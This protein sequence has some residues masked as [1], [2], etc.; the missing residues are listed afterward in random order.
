[1]TYL[2]EHMKIQRKLSPVFGTHKLPF[3]DNDQNLDQMSED[4]TT[5]TTTNDTESGTKRKADDNAADVIEDQES[6][7]VRVKIDDQADTAEQATGTSTEDTAKAVKVEE[8]GTTETEPSPEAKKEDDLDRTE[9]AA[10]EVGGALDV[11]AEDKEKESSLENTDSAT[12]EASIKD[13]GITESIPITSEDKDDNTIEA[14]TED[15]KNTNGSEEETEVSTAVKE[16]EGS[17]EI[18]EEHDNV[19]RHYGK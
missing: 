15:D 17:D 14:K 2:S 1:M 6:R 7:R 4:N 5:T 13:D 10:A 18:V 16:D 19:P 3:N 9:S 8:P 12:Q 11:L